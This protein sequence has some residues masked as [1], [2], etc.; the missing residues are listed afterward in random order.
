MKLKQTLLFVV[1][2]VSLFSCVSSKKFK[3]AQAKIDSLT[4][5]NA[6][7]AGDLKNWNDLTATDASQKSALQNQID[8][9]TKQINFLKKNHHVTLKQ[10]HNLSAISTPQPNHTTNS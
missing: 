3:A 8:A 9:L 7:L 5:A 6:K 1:L 10:L 4:A 2:S